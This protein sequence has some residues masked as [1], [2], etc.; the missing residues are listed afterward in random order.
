MP[1]QDYSHY[2]LGMSWGTSHPEGYG[3]SPQTQ[4]QLLAILS[5]QSKGKYNLCRYAYL[6]FDPSTSQGD[7]VIYFL[8]NQRSKKWVDTYQRGEFEVVAMETEGKSN[9]LVGP[10]Q[11]LRLDQGSSPCTRVGA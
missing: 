1:I 10:G 6:I 5:G 9:T 3:A 4:A 8:V 7:K 11:M 2:Q